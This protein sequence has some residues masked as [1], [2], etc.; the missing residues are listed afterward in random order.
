MRIV[1]DPDLPVLLV[2][3][4]PLIAASFYIWRRW[5]GQWRL[6][7]MMPLVFIAVNLVVIRPFW[8]GGREWSG[9]EAVARYA[10]VL[11]AEFLAIGILVLIRGAVRARSRDASDRAE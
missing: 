4:I 8:G 10:L 9:Y 1:F 2:P 7:A 11:P 3:L 6:V 5:R